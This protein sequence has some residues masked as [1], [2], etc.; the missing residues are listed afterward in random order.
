MVAYC[1]D[2]HT[3][4]TE[5]ERERDRDRGKQRQR[6]TETNLLGQPD[7]SYPDFGEIGFDM[8]YRPRHRRE[9]PLVTHRGQKSL[10]STAQ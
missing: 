5:R 9:R 7:H 6:Q 10:N 1:S 8:G 2:R 3:E 4:N